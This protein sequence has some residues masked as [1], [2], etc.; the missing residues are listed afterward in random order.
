MDINEQ[1]RYL[2]RAVEEAIKTGEKN[3]E[4]RFSDYPFEG[5]WRDWQ[6]LWLKIKQPLTG[7]VIPLDKELVQSK[8]GRVK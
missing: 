8:E 2:K 6:I 5:M 7:A 4:F 1:R 3:G